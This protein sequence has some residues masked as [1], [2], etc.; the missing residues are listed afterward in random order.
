MAV[1]AQARVM[2]YDSVGRKLLSC[3]AFPGTL[4]V[5]LGLAIGGIGQ[6][7]PAELVVLV[8]AV[9]TAVITFVLEVVHPH[10][11]L[12]SHSKGDIKTDVLHMLL[13]EMLP[14]QIFNALFVTGLLVVAGQAS[15]YIG[16]DLWP[17]GWPYVAQLALALTIGEFFHYWWHRFCHEFDLLWRLH[18]THHSAPRLYFLNAGR[19]HPI[20][21]LAG[22]ALQATP[23]LLLG[24]NLETL[25]LF[26]LFTAIHGLFQH[27]NIKV[28]LGPLNYIFS[29][30]ELHRW[31]H[32]RNIEDANANYGGNLIIWDTIFGTRYFPEDRE[33]DPEDVGFEGMPA[34]PSNYTAQLTSPFRWKKLKEEGDRASSPE[35][36]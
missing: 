23:I 1:D 12:W 21:T 29:M 32:S 28:K 35:K 24:C 19:F 36:R 2:E 5:M 16:F 13:S 11:V 14:P 20:D 15:A 7:Y 6:G 18:A 30:A 27:A 31:H 33:H 22:Y 34:F 17:Y 25:A 8:L 4:V 3:V 9:S 26:S 10:T